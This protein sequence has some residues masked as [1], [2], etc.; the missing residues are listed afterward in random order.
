MMKKIFNHP[1]FQCFIFLAIF[2]PC[3][4]IG[5]QKKTPFWESFILLGICAI[6][7]IVFVGY[8]IHQDNQIFKRLQLKKENKRIEK[9]KRLQKQVERIKSYLK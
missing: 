8:A 3:F 6:E 9:E 2:Y 7:L 1:A 5:A 4:W